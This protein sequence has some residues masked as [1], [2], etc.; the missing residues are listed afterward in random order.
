MSIQFAYI[1][2]VQSY[3]TDIYLLLLGISMPMI[4]SWSSFHAIQVHYGR[5]ISL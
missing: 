1:V 2:T 5:A 4:I 3:L